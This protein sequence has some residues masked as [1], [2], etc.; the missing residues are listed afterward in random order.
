MSDTLIP[1]VKQHRDGRLSWAA[2]KRL[3]KFNEAYCATTRDVPLFP[4]YPNVLDAALLKSF[5]RLLFATPLDQDIT[6]SLTA[7]WA[8]LPRVA[9]EWRKTQ[10]S[11]LKA[12]MLKAGFEPNL[13]LA[14]SFFKCSF[15]HRLRVCQY[16]YILAHRCPSSYPRR[17]SFDSDNWKNY[18]LSY[19]SRHRHTSIWSASQYMVD[20]EALKRVQSIIQACGLDPGTATHE[21]IDSLN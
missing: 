3:D 6:E 16:P 15:C 10:N 5:S 7:A 21:D 12:L 14:T 1:I 13:N 2:E 4:I 20:G 18:A 17:E 11:A 8:Q 19:L 9:D